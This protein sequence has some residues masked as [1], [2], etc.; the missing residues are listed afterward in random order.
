MPPADPA[1][2]RAGSTRRDTRWL[3]LLAGALLV[4][5]V[6]TGVWEQ[7]NPVERPDQVRWVPIEQAHA[8]ARRQHRPILYDFT[9]DW[10]PPCRAMRREVFADAKRARLI[11]GLTVPVRVLDRQREEGRNPAL[12]DSLQRA[13]DVEA[14][15]TLVIVGADGGTPQRSAGYEGAAATTQWISNA[16]MRV[17]FMLPAGPAG[18]APGAAPGI[19]HP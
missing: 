8:E 12:V 2:A 19:A 6:A 14:F 18:G 11:E 7:K 4:A 10:C 1:P 15:P 13:F 9:A 3:W 5:R 17:R 16:V